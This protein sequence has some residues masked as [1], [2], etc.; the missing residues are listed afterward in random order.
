[1]SLKSEPKNQEIPNCIHLKWVKSYALGKSYGFC[2][3]KAGKTNDYSVPVPPHGE[4]CPQ[5]AGKECR[6]YKP[7]RVGFPSPDLNRNEL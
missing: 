3:N 2:D 4:F 7:I 6:W 5:L 1:M